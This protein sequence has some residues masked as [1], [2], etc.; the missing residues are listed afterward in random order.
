MDVIDTVAAGEERGLIDP[1]VITEQ[2]Y[3]A[4]V[5]SDGG[6]AEEAIRAMKDMDGLVALPLVTSV[7]EYA[8]DLRNKYYERGTRGFSYADAIHLAMAT[9]HHDCHTL[10]SGDP[11]F[12]GIEEI[13]TVV[14]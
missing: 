2:V 11:D 5:A 1:T 13:E 3:R 4:R 9:V 10:Y 12:A 8:A 14:L 7:A 6:T